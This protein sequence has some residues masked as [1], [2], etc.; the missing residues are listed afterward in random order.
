M[1]TLTCKHVTPERLMSLELRISCGAVLPAPKRG[2]AVSTPN[3][4]L[5]SEQVIGRRTQSPPA[6][7][8]E[9]R[10]SS[11]THTRMRLSRSPPVRDIVG[12]PSVGGPR[13]LP[14][15]SLTA[16]LHGR[17]FAEFSPAPSQRL[18]PEV[19]S[20]GL[21]Q[22][23]ATVAQ[24]FVQGRVLWCGDA[25]HQ[26]PPTGGLGVNTGLQGMHNA[27]WK[28]AW[29]VLGRAGWKLVTTYET[30]RRGVT[31][32]ITRQSLQNS[33]NVQLINAAA[34]TGAHGP[35]GA[36]QVVA[37]SRR[38][39]N[40]LGVEFGAV[41]QSSDVVADGTKPP[42]VADSYSD[43][44]PSA[45]PGARAPHV[46]LGHSDARLSTLDLFGSAFTLLAGPAGAAWCAAAAS[47]ARELGIPIDCYRI[48]GP[49]L[50]D[51]GGFTA[52][53]GLCEDGAV[54]VRPDG[55]VAW[56]GVTGPGSTAVLQEAVAQI[57]ATGR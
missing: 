39:G 36:E 26:F 42:D 57:V 40:H 51:P 9:R 29:Y 56:R 45:T 18:A 24:R 3:G 15:S 5:V 37:E 43:Y 8:A 21:W 23:N 47:V 30:E 33:I 31:Q 54:L 1:T 46:W 55:H 14:R 53:Y 34:A 38:Y 25:A 19:L 44:V 16:R 41:Y 22:L 49:G 11:P 20:L 32:T 6:P 28:L 27:V 13:T 52:A 17:T 50:R 2:A 4:R 10:R 48:G 12:S 7:R 35:L